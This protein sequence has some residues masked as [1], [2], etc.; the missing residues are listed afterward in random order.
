ML[1]NGFN[2]T[3]LFRL[4]PT[5][6]SLED[7]TILCGSNSS[8][9]SLQ[10]CQCSPTKTSRQ[11]LQEL[12]HLDDLSSREQFKLAVLYVAKGQYTQKE[13]LANSCGSE[14]YNKFLQLLG[15]DIDLATHR[16]FN[17]R[18]DYYLFFR[19]LLLLNLFYCYNNNANNIL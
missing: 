4:F 19:L 3:P 8:N 14:L 5:H 18:F 10:L 16:G 17:G 2:N 15:T 1:S 9:T 6:S 13:I 7:Y 11:I 12:R